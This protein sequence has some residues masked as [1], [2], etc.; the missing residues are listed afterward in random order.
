ML[1]I[2][3]F[4]TVLLAVIAAFL[5]EQW[6]TSQP[7]GIQHAVTYSQLCAYFVFMMDTGELWY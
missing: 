2:I 3:I 1:K 5:F 6:F 7:A 4:R